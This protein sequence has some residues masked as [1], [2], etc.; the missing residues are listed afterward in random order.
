[1]VKRTQAGRRHTIIDMLQ[2]EALKPGRQAI[3]DLLR[4]AVGLVELGYA[5]LL[6]Q[7]PL[8]IWHSYVN[9][10]VHP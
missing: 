2:G 9:A 8:V 1:M 6:I 7:Q 10:R 3:T 5:S 4:A